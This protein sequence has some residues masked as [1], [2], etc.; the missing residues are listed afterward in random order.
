MRTGNTAGTATVGYATSDTAS[1]NCA[2]LN[3]GK[4]SSH[5]DYETTV[6]RLRFAAGVATV[7]LIWART[8]VIL[9]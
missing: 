3:S 6:G 9:G 2:T 4:A 1:T 8:P 7:Y 5:C